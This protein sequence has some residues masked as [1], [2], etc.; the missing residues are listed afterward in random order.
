M[1]LKGRKLKWSS[2]A[3]LPVVY[4]GCKNCGPSKFM[5]AE[6]SNVGPLSRANLPVAQASS[7]A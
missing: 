4:L 3:A 7:S 5:N 6:E 2:T 1:K